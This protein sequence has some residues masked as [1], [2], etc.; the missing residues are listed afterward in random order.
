MRA[1]G[2]PDAFPARDLGVQVAAKQLGL[3]DNSRQLIEHSAQWRPWRAYATQH[4]WTSLDHAVNQWPPL[5]TQSPQ[6]EQA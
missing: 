5:T 4:L 6:Q 1:L 2:D 3:P